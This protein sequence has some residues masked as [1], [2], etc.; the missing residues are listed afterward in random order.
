MP[1]FLRTLL[2][3]APPNLALACPPPAPGETRDPTGFFDPA[4]V[5]A[6]FQAA[7]WVTAG[8]VVALV[9]VCY[10]A[11]STTVGPRFVRRW[12]MF[13]IATVFVAALAG[14]AVVALWPTHALASSC[15]TLPTAFA[16]HLPLN[17]VLNRAFAGLLWGA[18]L[19]FLVSA[20]LAWTVGLVPSAGNGFFHNRG[21][22]VPRWR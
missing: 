2:G 9:V 12:W 14:G 8:L 18:V 13:G 1:V 21:C 17:V 4:S 15:E 6:A 19:Y 3:L 7:G 11:N 20:L 16:R 10:L 5:S 22:P